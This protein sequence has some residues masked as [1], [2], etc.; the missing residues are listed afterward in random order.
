[1]HA[2]VLANPILTRLLPLI[3]EDIEK[4]LLIKHEIL[5]SIFSHDGEVR[6]LSMEAGISMVADGTDMAE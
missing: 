3:Y 4:L 1:M 5:H 6:C 2:V